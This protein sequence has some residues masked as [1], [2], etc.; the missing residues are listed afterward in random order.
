MY[1]KHK[2]LA[3]L[4]RNVSYSE[5]IKI[6]NSYTRKFIRFLLLGASEEEL[7]RCKKKLDSL[8]GELKRRRAEKLMEEE[9]DQ[10]KI[11]LNVINNKA[12]RN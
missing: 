6:L 3:M 2:W 4:L 10:E 9:I 8:L 11:L 7:A 1:K 12:L 5:L